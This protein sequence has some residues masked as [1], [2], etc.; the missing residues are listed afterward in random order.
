MNEEGRECVKWE[1]GSH[2][3]NACRV[4]WG[5]DEKE[6]GEVLNFL[7]LT[8]WLGREMSLILLKRRQC[9]PGWCG[10]VD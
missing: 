2:V 3:L 6:C 10:S 4:M 1:T 9:R 8:F 5:W 7:A